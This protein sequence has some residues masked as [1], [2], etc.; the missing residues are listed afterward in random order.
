MKI[1]VIVEYDKGVLKFEINKMII[2]V[3]K[4]GFDVDLLFVGENLFVM[5]E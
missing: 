2:V 3:V 4:L 1:L 5:S